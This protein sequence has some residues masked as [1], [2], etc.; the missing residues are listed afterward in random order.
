[1]AVTT[2]NELTHAG[3]Y[4]LEVIY[5]VPYDAGSAGRDA[6][7]CGQFSMFPDSGPCLS[8]GID[9]LVMWRVHFHKYPVSVDR[10]RHQCSFATDPGSF[11]LS[12]LAWENSSAEL[13]AWQQKEIVIKVWPQIPTIFQSK[14]FSIF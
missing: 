3:G 5:A 2:A 11:S 9:T 13:T 10:Y 6:D 14:P 1:M 8:Q 7:G 4:P 12:M